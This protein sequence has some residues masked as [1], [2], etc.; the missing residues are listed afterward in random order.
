MAITKHCNL[1]AADVRHS[2]GPLET[3]VTSTYKFSN[4]ARQISA[5]GEHFS[6]YLAKVVLRMRRNCWFQASGQ[7]ADT[8]VGSTFD[9]LI[10]N[11]CSISSVTFS[12]SVANL[13]EIEQSAANVLMIYQLLSCR[14]FVG[15]CALFNTDSH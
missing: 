12:K 8:A 11:V 10:L 14:F 6:V 7:N 15:F 2:Y 1:K 5:I 4:S 9:P 13:S 3:H